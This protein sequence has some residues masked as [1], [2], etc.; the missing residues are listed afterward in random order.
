MSEY[1]TLVYTEQGGSTM[2]V[3]SGGKI[4][5]MSGGELELSA[6]ATFDVDC[7]LGISRA[8]AAP[9]TGD[10]YG[11]GAEIE[12]TTSGEHGGHVN[13]ASAWVN[14][15]A[16][17]A[18]G[19]NMV[20]ARNDGIWVNTSDSGDLSNANAIFGARMH[21][22]SGG[23][24]SAAAPFSINVDGTTVDALFYLYNSDGTAE[25][26]YTEDG[27]TEDSKIGAVPLYIDGATSTK[28]WVRIYDGAS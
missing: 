22:S 15:N 26:G 13:A 18:A 10:G 24:E 21:L 17:V 8:M 11:G 2:Y 28:Y 12:I 9:N 14:V 6:G 4:D 5:V 25:M 19:G 1:N 20:C 7:K 16:T 23:N 27:T 3:D